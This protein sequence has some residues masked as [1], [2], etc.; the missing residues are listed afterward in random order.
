MERPKYHKFLSKLEASKAQGSAP[1]ENRVCSRPPAAWLQTR[2]C[3][4]HLRIH[5]YLEINTL[6]M[7]SSKMCVKLGWVGFKKWKLRASA[8]AK[9]LPTAPASHMDTGQK[10][11]LSTSSPAP[12]LQTGKGFKKGIP[13]TPLANPMAIFLEGFSAVNSVSTI[14][15][16]LTVACSV[17]FLPSQMFI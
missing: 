12:C 8:V 17:R 15:A 16:S 9:L 2:K 3:E 7:C 13:V 6:S 14:A 5:L 11:G 10:P 1:G 4:L